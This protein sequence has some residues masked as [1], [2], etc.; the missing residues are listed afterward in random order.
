MIDYEVNVH[1]K[2]LMRMEL[3]NLVL[4]IILVH[5]HFNQRQNT[6]SNKLIYIIIKDLLH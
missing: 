6:F 1:E 5:F 2:V 4:P 3:V